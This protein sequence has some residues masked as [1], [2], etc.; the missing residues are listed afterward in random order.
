MLL[1]TIL[2]A[3]FE[4]FWLAFVVDKS[5]PTADFLAIST[6]VSIAEILKNN[7]FAVEKSETFFSFSFSI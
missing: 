1:S 5:W 7:G 2:A 4:R 6:V 3:C